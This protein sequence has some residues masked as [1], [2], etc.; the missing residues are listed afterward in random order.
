M[1]VISIQKDDEGV[2]M[3]KVKLADPSYAHMIDDLVRMTLIQLAIQ[4]LFFASSPGE[5][6]FWTCNFVMLMLFIWLGVALYWLV[7]KM[8]VR[9]V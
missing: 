3:Y 5:N 4:F 8:L 7:F 9:V 1:A 2:A 6:P